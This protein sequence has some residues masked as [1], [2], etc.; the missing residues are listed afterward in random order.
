MAHVHRWTWIALASIVLSACVTAPKAQND[1]EPAGEVRDTFEPSDLLVD[2]QRA[3]TLNQ[4]QIV[5]LVYESLLA[6]DPKTLA[7]APGAADLPRV[8]DNGL[9]YHFTLRPGTVYSDG[10]AV[11][12]SDY[13]YG[14]S[15]L[16]DPA[17]VASYG[18]FVF[19]IV[20]CE[21]WRSMNAAKDAPDK[22]AATRRDLF[23]RGIVV[24]SDREFELRL[25][26]PAPY[27][28]SVMALWITA[29]VRQADVEGAGDLWY[30]DTSAYIG[31]GPFVLTEW[32]AQKRLVFDRNER[33]R[34]PAKVKRWT[35][36]MLMASAAFEAYRAGSLDRTRVDNVMALVEPAGL[37]SEMTI[38]PGSCTTYLRLNHTRPPLDDPKV[39]LALAKSIDRTALV[40]DLHPSARPANSFI[41]PGLPGHDPN[42]LA[43]ATDV[44]AARQ[45]IAESRYAGTDAMRMTWYV[46]KGLADGITGVDSQYIAKRWREVLGLDI[47]VEVIPDLTF[48]EQYRNMS[49]RAL[50]ERSGWCADYPDQQDWLSSQFT[51]KGQTASSFDDKGYRNAQ[52]DAL[53]AEADRSTD[54]SRRDALYL[55]VSRTVSSDVAFIWLFYNQTVWLQKP[56]LDAL[57][58][59]ALDRGGLFHPA[60][61]V[62][63]PH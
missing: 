47:Q 39:R 32:I 43:Q 9:T 25:R 33:Y 20:G 62:V 23:A 2:P 5:D 44:V 24:L 3:L 18:P 52:V 14:I 57:H 48:S 41:P 12:A 8:S 10:S 59:N 42:D 29:P 31:N 28:S 16:C 37:S 6:L 34:S 38:T 49:T 21:R 56:W 61:V 19:A 26:E 51:T 40:K 45:L 7:P 15:R 30:K 17:V 1:I 27:F 36:T 60:D 22:L 50:F 58:A 4:V 54:Q 53:I 11:K 35:I 13:A 46:R 63:H 55:T